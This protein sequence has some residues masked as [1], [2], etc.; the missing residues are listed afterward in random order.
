MASTRTSATVEEVL[1]NLSDYLDRV[2][3]GGERFVLFRD[4]ED[5]A[6]LGPPDPEMTRLADLP[7]ALRSL[8]R[9]GR[10]DAERFTADIEAGRREGGA[11]TPD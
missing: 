5:V 2:A 7:D 10:E 9:L 1:L 3:H 11:L 4:G 8:P 6:E